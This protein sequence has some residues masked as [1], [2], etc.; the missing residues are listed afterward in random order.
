MTQE[1]KMSPMNAETRTALGEVMATFEAFKSAND[2]RLA[3]IE[4]R[5]GADTLLEDQVRRI[6]KGLAEQKSALDRLVMEA[7][8][9]PRQVS[10]AVSAG[11][12]RYLQRGDASGLAEAKSLEAGSPGDGGYVVPVETENR[13]DALIAEASPMRRLAQVRTVEGGLYR[14]PVSRGGA[15]AGWVGESEARPETATP[16]MDVIDLPSAELYAM[17]AATQTLL[18][19][20]SLDVEQWL[21][22]EVRGVFAAQ[23]SQA[24]LHGDGVNKPRG[25]LHY[26]RAAEGSQSFGQIGYVATGVAGG[27]AASDPADVL[28]DLIYAPQTRYRARGSFLMNR[29]TLSAVRRFKDADG[30]Y[31]WQPGLSADGTSRLLGYPV[32]EAE[33]M[34]DIG[35]D[36][37][38]LAF[39]DFQAAYLIL[40][41][42]GVAVLRDPYTAKPYVLFYTTKRVGGGVQDFEAVK[43]LKFGVS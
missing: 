15:A 24:F 4:A 12:T 26:G 41:R 1:T 23:E 2:Q 42:Q 28:I 7:A 27:F 13:I 35:N 39:G 29:Q 14:K 11:L 17:P 43:L 38:A 33:D 3:E 34:P 6:D 31:L 9:P 5:H 19:D 8:R 37:V 22:E 36:A 25:L 21:A 30:Q 10:T 16:V 32:V 40:D 18:E 20:A